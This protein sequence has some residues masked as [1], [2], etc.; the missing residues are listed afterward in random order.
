MANDIHKKAQ[1]APNAPLLAVIGGIALGA[2]TAALL[3]KLRQEDQLRRLV[4]KIGKAANSATEAAA[5]AIRKK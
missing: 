2:I 1:D 4:D 5:E 3:P